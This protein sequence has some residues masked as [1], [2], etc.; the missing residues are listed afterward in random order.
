[1]ISLKRLQNH[2]QRASKPRKHISFLFFI[3]IYFSLVQA[4]ATT[5]CPDPMP[6]D[7]YLKSA[8]DI[9]LGSVISSTTDLTVVKIVES[10][11]G[12]SQTTISIPH[13]LR[14]TYSK[15][16]PTD[17]PL[18]LRL[19]NGSYA[20]IVCE[21]PADGYFT[22]QRI[23]QLR[24]VKNQRT[25]LEDAIAS[26][27][28]EA[29]PLIALAKFYEDYDTYLAKKTYR[30]AVSLDQGTEAL[31]GFMRTLDMKDSTWA[32]EGLE[33]AEEVLNRSPS[34]TVAKRLKDQALA[35]AGHGQLEDKADLSHG[36]FELLSL[37][38]R[39]MPSANLKESII[40]RLEAS[41]ADL[42]N[43]DLTGVKIE[44]SNFA[45]ANLEGASLKNAELGFTTLT[46]ANFSKTTGL[47]SFRSENA[48]DASF[49]ESDLSGANLTIIE[50]GLSF[51]LAPYYAGYLKTQDDETLNFKPKPQIN[52]SKASLSGARFRIDGLQAD[53]SNSNLSSAYFELSDLRAANFLGANLSQ[54]NFTTSV[55]DC[56]TKFPPDFIPSTTGLV[57]LPGPTTCDKQLPL[58][59][60]GLNI[61]GL[62]FAGLDLRNASFKGA[63]LGWSQSFR[64]AGS[65]L[66]GVDLSGTS[67]DSQNMVGANLEN[68]KLNNS[69]LTLRADVLWPNLTNAEL[70]GTHIIIVNYTHAPITSDRMK[71]LQVAKTKGAIYECSD[72]G[73]VPPEFVNMGMVGD[74]ER[75]KYNPSARIDLSGLDFK[76]IDF[77]G[78]DLRGVDFRNSK[79]DNAASMRGIYNDSTQWPEG[80][81]PKAAHLQYCPT[82]SWNSCGH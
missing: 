29:A 38:D 40:T 64:L 8:N 65:N 27:P 25:Q 24:K 12:A 74:M 53:F 71:A 11:K 56:R 5:P 66:T 16:L 28:S 46:H 59:Y 69:K 54:T 32:V 17:K 15:E 7:M 2:R 20:S 3:F 21:P 22:A 52:F 67:L 26:H 80:F 70:K 82:G 42:T 51:P 43:A 35:H 34:N 4:H 61:G 50:H 41:D 62:N 33:A 10:F 75:C 45:H 60:D 23:E 76:D 18:L 55:Y 78:T 14:D 44:R 73:V 77:R 79:L 39:H 19:Q 81:D 37:T 57:P 68:A 13:L 9:F 36:K 49:A 58:V 31:E 47:K 48:A 30:K 72:L 63:K 1:M 6:I